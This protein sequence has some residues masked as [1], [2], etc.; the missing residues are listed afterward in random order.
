MGLKE[1][2]LARVVEGAEVEVES[3]EERYRVVHLRHVGDMVEGLGFGVSDF[4]FWVPG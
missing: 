4:G 1:S 2:E 3:L